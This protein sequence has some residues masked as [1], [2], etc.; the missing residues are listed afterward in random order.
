MFFFAVSCHQFK[1]FCLKIAVLFWPTWLILLFVLA[2]LKIGS[3]I[4]TV[5][6][7]D[8]DK[9]EIVYGIEPSLFSDGSKFFSIN[10][11]TGEVFLKSSVKGQV[12]LVFYLFVLVHCF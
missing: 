3:Q 10:S 5:R 12:S 11:K 1:K 6:T 2:Y 4:T 9:D 8:E 7:K